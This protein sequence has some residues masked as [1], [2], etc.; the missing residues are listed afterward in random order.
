MP[1]PLTPQ[2]AFNKVAKHLLRQ[3]ERSADAAGNCLYRGPRGL[4]CAIGAL[5]PRRIKPP[6]N[7]NV[8]ALLFS[9]GASRRC[10][11][12]VEHIGGDEVAVELHPLLSELQS[13]HDDVPVES[14]RDALLNTANAHDLSAAAL[15]VAP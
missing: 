4:R 12:W 11:A 7:A 10:Q 2:A 1:R 9:S 15:E 6:E 3:N 8:S 13:I 5:I 14:W